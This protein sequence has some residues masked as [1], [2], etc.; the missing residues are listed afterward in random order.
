M[1]LRL[2]L[3]ILPVLVSACAGPQ[4]KDTKQIEMQ[5]IE[6]AQS[7]DVSIESV[8]ERVRNI[9]T[10]A[11]KEDLYFYS[12]NYMANGETAMTKAESA[13]NA[14]NQA[15]AMTEAL[16]AEAFFKRGL[17]IKPLAL[18]QLDDVFRGMDMLRGLKANQY[19]ASD[20]Q[21]IQADIQET[22]EL[23]EQGNTS[24]LADEQKSLLNDIYELE[25]ETLRVIFLRPVEIALES[26][27]DVD[28]DEFAAQSYAEAEKAMD[29]LEELIKQQPKQREQI[30]IDSQNAVRL[31]QHALHVAQAAKPLLRL[32]SKSAEKHILSIEQFLMRIGTALG[33]KDVTHLPLNS[34]SIALA[35]TAEILAKQAKSKLEQ[36]LEQ[37]RT[38]NENQQLQQRIKKLE[39]L[40]EDAQNK[41]RSNSVDPQPPTPAK[42]TQVNP[43]NNANKSVIVDTQTSES[44]KE[45]NMNNKSAE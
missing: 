34:Q 3:I 44:P 12:P 4:L 25:I 28:A 37:N 17:A 27:E 10:D 7:A 33:E 40:L 18:Q 2:S 39:R 16:K 21:D 26:A 19:L 45:T 38:Q 43:D 14:N 1:L 6:Q 20:F 31:A 35:Q 42:S 29:R 5:A 13:L 23:I 30:K 22:I 9:Q 41:A 11:R 32:D 24:E 15:L 8:F 36:Q